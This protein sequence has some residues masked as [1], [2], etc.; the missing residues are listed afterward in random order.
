MP[1]EEFSKPIE[2]IIEGEI[3]LKFYSPCQKIVKSCI[4]QNN[5]IFYHQLRLKKPDYIVRKNEINCGYGYRYTPSHYEWQNVLKIYKN[6]DYIDKLIEILSAEKWELE[7]SIEIRFSRI[8]YDIVLEEDQ[9]PNKGGVPNQVAVYL[10]PGERLRISKYNMHTFT[11]SP[12]KFEIYKQLKFA[13]LLY[14]WDGDK[15][16]KKEIF[17]RI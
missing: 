9:W 15:G 16:L 1:K 2:K 14:G 6:S 5:G 17:D 7:E 12:T 13:Y 10:M 8:V 4:K 3:F 11:Y